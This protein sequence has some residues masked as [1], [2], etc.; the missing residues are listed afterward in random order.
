[1]TSESVPALVVAAASTAQ[2]RLALAQLRLTLTNCAVL[3]LVG[4]VFGAVVDSASLDHTN[5]ARDLAVG[6]GLLIGLI[7]TTP[8]C[9][10]LQRQLSG[11]LNWHIRANLVERGQLLQ[12]LEP[13]PPASL[14]AALAPAWWQPRARQ[15]TVQAETEQALSG[16]AC[17]QRLELLIA[18]YPRCCRALRLS[19][20]PAAFRLFA[21]GTLALRLSALPLVVGFVFVLYLAN[22]MLSPGWIELM[23]LV[24]ASALGAG[25]TTASMLKLLAS[26]ALREVLAEELGAGGPQ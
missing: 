9:A 7:G 11:E 26:A 10:F 15:W 6:A 5:R 14:Q 24:V 13:L 3:A 25:A 20:Y 19:A 16:Q 21:L 4:G 23:A 17:A 18:R 8:L 2:R 1:M 22:A 12:A